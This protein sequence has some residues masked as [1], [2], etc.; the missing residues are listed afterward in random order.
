[1]IFVTK[2][3]NLIAGMEDSSSQEDV[4]DGKINVKFPGTKQANPFDDKK[5]VFVGQ[6]V[7]TL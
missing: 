2:E 1:M 4:Y 3:L 6:L 5:T 7:T